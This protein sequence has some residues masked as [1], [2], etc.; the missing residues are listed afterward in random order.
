MSAN[1]ISIDLETLGT[2]PRSAIIAIGAVRFSPITGEVDMENTF[3]K[4]IDWN[5]ATRGR[6]VS[7]DTL[8]WWMGQSN[9]AR[10][11]ITKGGNSTKQVLEEFYG[12]FPSGGKAWGNGAAF[13]VA[14][15]E[16]ALLQVGLVAPWKFWDVR[17]MRTVVAIGAGIADKNAIQRAGTHHNALDDAA[18]QARTIAHIW[19]AVIGKNAPPAVQNKPIAVTNL[20]PA[21]KSL[22]DDSFL[23]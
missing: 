12:W 21:P 6:Q 23:D 14:M 2:S 18:H 16:D 8:R 10:K 13:D 15:L 22:S 3:Y 4:R 11:E 1:D 19:R 17:D 5:S 7:G 9:E 20:G